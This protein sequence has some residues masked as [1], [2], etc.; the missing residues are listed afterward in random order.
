MAEPV[1][2]MAEPPLAGV[3][4]LEAGSYVSAPFAGQMLADLGA[5]VIKVEAP[6]RG[7]AFRRFNRPSGP[8]NPMFAN[9][10]RGK[11]SVLVD[12]KDPA[13]REA[14]LEFAARSDVWLSNWRPGVA[15]RLGLG[16]D[17]LESRNARLIRVY[18]SGYG[19]EGPRAQAPVFDTIMQATTG[20]THA[21][22]KGDE[23]TVLAGYPID[24]LTASMAAQAVLAAL[25]ARERHGRGERIDLSMLA[26]GAYVNFV[27]LFSNRTFL[28]GEPAESRNL[29]A[30]GLR[31]LPTKDGWITVAPVSGAAVRAMCEVAGHPE[32]GEELRAMSDQSRVAQAL[33]ERLDTVLPSRTADEWLRALA[34]RDVPAARCLT[35][36]EHLADPQVQVQEIYR[37]EQWEGVGAVRTVRYPALF[38]GRRLGT[39]GPAPAAG[40]DTLRY[41]GPGANKDGG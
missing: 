1:A 11:G 16:D 3:R 10:N 5:E 14:L 7:D 13:G 39:A 6:P 12:A 29:H 17:V 8:Y 30:T 24:K 41:L 40:R 34:E 25:Y 21:L 32:W 38:G 37:T 33:F 2:V 18:V 19:E 22:S 20:L 35:I 31:P 28:D 26:A 36:D 27:E 23:P 15:A 4:V 9:S